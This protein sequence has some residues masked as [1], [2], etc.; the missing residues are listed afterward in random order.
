VPSLDPTWL[1]RYESIQHSSITIVIWLSIS[2]VYIFSYVQMK[3]S[4]HISYFVFYV[5][6]I[7]VAT[8]R[9]YCFGSWIWAFIGAPYT[10]ISWVRIHE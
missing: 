4:W 5:P 7:F 2:C 6:V 10:T 3:S 8:E 9:A 1:I